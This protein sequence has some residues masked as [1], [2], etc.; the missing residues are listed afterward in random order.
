[1]GHIDRSFLKPEQ[2]HVKVL[3]AYIKNMVGLVPEARDAIKIT[4]TLL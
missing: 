1:M 3:T 2:I 4:P